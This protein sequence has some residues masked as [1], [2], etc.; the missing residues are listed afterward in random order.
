MGSPKMAKSAMKQ[1]IWR[2]RIGAPF[3][4]VLVA[5]VL[6]VVV[7]S[8]QF[9]KGP[10]ASSQFA[11][12]Q[13]DN[14][15]R[16]TRDKPVSADQDLE[17]TVSSKLEGEDT[18]QIRLE[19]GQSPN[20]EAAIEEQKPSQAAAIDQDDNTLNPGLKQASGDERSA[21]GSDSLSKESPPQSQEGDGGTAESGAEPY[22]KCTAQSDIKICDLSNPR[23]DIC[24]LCGDARTIGQSSTVV[25]VPQNRASNGEEWIIRAQSRKHLP[26]IKKVTIKSVNS[27][28]PEPIC[29]SKHHI[30]AIVF[31]LG[32]L[33]ANVWHDFS[34]VLVPL[35]LTARQFN[36]DVQ[37]IITNN[38]P[39]FIK[40]YSAIFSRLTRHE[41][42]DFDSDGQIRCYPHVIVGLRSHRDLGIDPSSS[43]QNYTMVDFR[44]F[45]REAYGLPAAEVDI[46]YK[47][48][49]DDPDKKPRI[50]LIDR[51]KSRRFVNVAH[52]VQGLDWFGFEVVKADPKIDSNL[53]EFVRLVDS[54]DA[55]MGVHGAGLTN[56]VFLRSG[57][58]VVHI[59]PY[60]I[61]FMADGFYGA[62]ARDMGLRHVEYSISPEEST[63]LEKYGWN[64]TVINDPETIRKGG[65][66]KVA[67]FYMSKQDIVLN[68]TRFGPSLLNAIE[69]IM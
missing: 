27:S 46:P 10:N 63:L 23:F 59:V 36:R 21:G 69:F 33:T 20:K 41:I 53:D 7:F 44:L 68:M 19:D 47:A 24:E 42:I 51:G 37:L 9:A 11:P 12:V 17:R 25:Y 38:Q 16:P 52:V 64:H 49:K 4:A 14:T 29:T 2:R 55:I 45:V 40:K 57:G 22:I 32:G 8:G 43:P 30:P 34:D 50:M 18:E 35:F 1:G 56:M 3:A 61:K 15:L 28:E 54:C 62:P 66:E 26:W 60:G 39:W 5:A 13:V 6:A 31:A 67:E 48:D 65:W 58:V